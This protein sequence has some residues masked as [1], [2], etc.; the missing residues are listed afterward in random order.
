MKI[1]ILIPGLL[2][3][4]L[5]LCPAASLANKLDGCSYKGIPL[6][7]KV[8]VV[9][10]LADFRVRQVDALADLKVEKV[11]AFASKCGQW[12]FVD[13]LEDFT[14]E[15]VDALEDFSIEYVHT[16]PGLNP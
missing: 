11:T 3:L 1:R 2:C 14:V 6:H 15:F 9:D 4:G 13:A 16:F 10:A 12:L 7:G 5:F 8:R